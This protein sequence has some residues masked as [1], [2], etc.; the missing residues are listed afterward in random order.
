MG[1]GEKKKDNK[2]VEIVDQMEDPEFHGLK[3]LGG[4]L[5]LFRWLFTN[6]YPHTPPIPSPTRRRSLARSCWTPRE[7]CRP[8]SNRICTQSKCYR[9]GKKE[10]GEAIPLLQL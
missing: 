1:E 5:R 9:K 2:D 3:K 7:C 10:K 6:S 8:D 4:W